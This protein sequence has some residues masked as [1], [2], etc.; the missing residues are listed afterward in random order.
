MP[1]ANWQKVR[2]GTRPLYVP[3]LVVLPGTPCYVC[4][5]PRSSHSVLVLQAP[6][7]VGGCGCPCFSP[8]CG[9][10]HILADHSWGVQPDPW[11]CAR[12]PCMK[13]G[14]NMAEQPKLPF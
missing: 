12:C 3:K 11:S 13:F 1:S 9:C 6:C 14:A 8:V 10:G 7:R 2:A 4:S 5:H